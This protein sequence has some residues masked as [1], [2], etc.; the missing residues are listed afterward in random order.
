[1]EFQADLILQRHEL[2]RERQQLTNQLVEATRNNESELK[3]LFGDRIKKLD[4]EIL[5]LDKMLAAAQGVFFNSYFVIHY[6]C[7]CSSI[8]YFS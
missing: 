4:E 7:F 2:Q 6:S 5:R 8:F 1:M 3:Q